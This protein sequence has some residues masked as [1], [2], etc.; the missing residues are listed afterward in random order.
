MTPMIAAIRATGFLFVFNT[1]RLFILIIVFNR[2]Y[3]TIHTSYYVYIYIIC[4]NAYCAYYIIILLLLLLAFLE[5]R[6]PG[7]NP[8]IGAYTE[9]HTSQ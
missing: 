2:R 8:L 1:E 9:L 7:T 5:S 3:N 6:I 4:E